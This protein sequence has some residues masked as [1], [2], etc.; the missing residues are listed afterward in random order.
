MSQGPD[1]DAAHSLRL[2]ASP[3][4]EESF[5]PFGRSLAPGARVELGG[6]SHGLAAVDV[7]RPGGLTISQLRRFP[8]TRRIILPMSDATMVFLLLG[9]KGDEGHPL[10][11]FHT[12]P[13]QGVMLEAGVWHAGPVVLEEGAVCEIL[14]A[15]GVADCVDVAPLKTL[16]R[17]DLVSVDLPGMGGEASVPL[18]L[19]AL[20]AVD[21]SPH[22]RGRV[23]AGFLRLVDVELGP[24][25][26]ELVQACA[27]ARGRRDD[28][29]GL[30]LRDNLHAAT[31]MVEANRGLRVLVADADLMQ[32]PLLLRMGQSKER[33]RDEEGRRS[34]VR[35][36]PVL[37]DTQG[38]LG[39]ARAGARRALPTT[40]TRDVLITVFFDPQAP[41]REVK[42]HLDAL[43]RMVR[44]F[45]RSREAARVVVG[46]GA[47][48]DR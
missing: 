42:D 21:L 2:P 33:I 47:A 5:A 35:G 14:D 48:A 6:E 30:A 18:D 17:V 19:G 27:D 9:K 38:I 36:E 31:L 28:D 41:V 11:A 1:S 4:T 3:L 25:T 37:C 34:S 46:L 15:R 8:T 20:G 43:S 16:A 40:E 7:W 26:E 22:A 29:G 13:G 24:A 10:H 39:S 45:T 23:A 12:T 32:P 44:A